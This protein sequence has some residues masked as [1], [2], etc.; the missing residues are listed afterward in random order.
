MGPGEWFVTPPG[1]DP[2]R[3]AGRIMPFAELEIRDEDNNAVPVG[4]EGEIAI[5]CEGQMTRPWGEPE[6]TAARRRDGGLLTGDIGRVDEHGS[7]YVID[8]V[9]DMIVSGGFNI[10]P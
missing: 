9:D 2:L 5:R 8:R 3:A 10:W 4:T 7:L 6:Q 1:S